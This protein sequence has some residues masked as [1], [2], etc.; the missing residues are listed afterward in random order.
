MTLKDNLIDKFSPASVSTKDEAVDGSPDNQDSKN[1]NSTSKHNDPSKL[2]TEGKSPSKDSIPNMDKS[3]KG[4]NTGTI[5]EQIEAQKVKE[6]KLNADEGYKSDLET[7]KKRHASETALNP[8]NPTVASRHAAE[9]GAL[10]DIHLNKL[11]PKPTQPKGFFEKA[12]SA[13]NKAGK[14]PL[15]KIAAVGGLM[16]AS[17]EVAAAS[18]IAMPSS[19]SKT[20]PS[21]P[22]SSGGVLETASNVTG[23]TETIGGL[24][25]MAMQTASRYSGAAMA[26][27]KFGTKLMPGVGLAAGAADIAYRKSQGDTTGAWMSAGIA[28]VSTVPVA[29]TA[30]AFL[31]SM[32]QVATDSMGITG[33]NRA[34]APQAP[35]FSKPQSSIPSYAKN[36]FSGGSSSA[37]NSNYEN[38][39]KYVSAAENSGAHS[40]NYAEQTQRSIED[41]STGIDNM[42]DKLTEF[43]ENSST[44]NNN[45]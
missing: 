45:E 43:L 40:N 22:P 9:V 2:N 28:A 3:S 20:T 7:M 38:N 42:A 14:S 31:G 10:Q 27:A 1:N 4:N 15:A 12:T 19:P 5:A 11:T 33:T 16:F 25:T 32:A 21:A 35:V 13:W 8:N 41:A 23:W 37:G 36:A 44:N 30:A 6:A 34:P 18:S 39:A 17:E 29:G 24:G 26:A